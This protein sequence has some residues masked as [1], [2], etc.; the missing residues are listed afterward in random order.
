[1]LLSKEEYRES[2][3]DMDID[4]LVKERHFLYREIRRFETNKITEEERNTKP[5]PLTLYECNNEYLVEVTKLINTKI[6]ELKELIPIE[7][8]YKLNYTETGFRAIYNNFIVYP[9]NKELK[10]LV[11]DYPDASKANCILTYGYIDSE[12]GLTLDIIACGKHRKDGFIFYDAP[13]DIRTIIRMESL[14]QHDFYYIDDENHQLCDKYEE[15]IEM[16]E[17]YNVN[18]EVENTRTMEF[19]DSSRNEFFP[20]DVLVH[21]VKDGLEY[22]GCWVRITGLGNDYLIGTLLN[23]PNQN[24]G[25]HINDTIAFFGQETK[26]HNVILISDMNPSKTL[27]Q[28]DLEDGTL[29]KDA[30]RKFNNDRNQDNFIDVLELLRDSYIWIPCHVVMEDED[31]EKLLNSDT[32][33]VLTSEEDIRL[34]PDILENNGHYYFPVFTTMEDMGEYGY[35]FSKIE[36]H[37]LE[38]IMLA[39]NNERDI[40]GIVI[41]AFSESFILDKDLFDLIETSKSRISNI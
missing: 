6:I 14:I 21:L 16:L 27:T 19:L 41:N 5:S 18:E 15:K 4:E 12:A 29:L 20:D 7:K 26:D 13:T 11:K 30:I 25:Y 39:K 3:K 9:L 31:I 10:T 38:S 35:Q 40:S 32:G 2:I 36:K 24:F 22:E 28:E 33:D 37:F 34:I 23:E 1:M 17:A 8:T